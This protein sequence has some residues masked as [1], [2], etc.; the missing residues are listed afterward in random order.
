MIQNMFK[1]K[2]A[3]LTGA[4]FLFIAAGISCVKNN[5]GSSTPE[6]IL[7]LRLMLQARL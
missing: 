5:S 4:M 7:T 6:I 3:V 2:N 1:L